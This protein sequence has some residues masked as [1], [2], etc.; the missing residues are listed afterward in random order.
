MNFR[1]LRDPVFLTQLVAAVVMAVSTFAIKLTDE[2]Q[3]VLNALAVSIAAIISAWKVSDGQ[4]ALLVG[5][6]K[7]LIAVGLAFGLHLTAEQ[8]LVL[9]TLLQLGAAMFV[10][11]QVGSPLPPPPSTAT[12]TVPVTQEAV[13]REQHG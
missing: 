8:Q 10:R 2:R 9:V 7:A 13:L 12:P 6:F 11:T 4:L 5:L 1:L 3:G